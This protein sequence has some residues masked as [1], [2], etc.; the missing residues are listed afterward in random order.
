[1]TDR[2]S[3]FRKTRAATHSAT[4]SLL[5]WAGVAAAT[6]ALAAFTTCARAED[7]VAQENLFLSPASLQ[8]MGNVGLPQGGWYRVTRKPGHLHVE[9]STLPMNDDPAMAEAEE[10]DTLYLRLPGTDVAEGRLPSVQF[11]NGV[12][13]PLL[14]H[15]YALQLGNTP[16]TL[17]VQNGLRN[18]AGVAYG[19][20]AQ[21]T[22]SYGGDSYVYQLGQYGWDS[23]IEAVADL[24]GDGMPDFIVSVGGNGGNEFLLLSS[25]ARPGRNEPTAVLASTGGC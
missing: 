2:I 17:S 15:T 19:E 1:M 6:I 16:F 7:L 3:H 13:R 20:G 8:E 23:V 12:L 22:V 5:G 9:A 24:D 11:S 18:S 21:Y 14:D 10:I 25:K 4:L